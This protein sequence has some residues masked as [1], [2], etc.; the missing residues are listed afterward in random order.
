MVA[1]TVKER[2]NDWHNSDEELVGIVSMMWL[3]D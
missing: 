1:E 2:F 3:D